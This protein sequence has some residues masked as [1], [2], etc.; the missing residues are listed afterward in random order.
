MD[1]PPLTVSGSEPTGESL[2]P[3]SSA[4]VN[5]RVGS[6][7][8]K[9]LNGLQGVASLFQ[10]LWVKRPYLQ[11]MSPE[12]GQPDVRNVQV[13]RPSHTPEHQGVSTSP[14]G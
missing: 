5:P 11:V 8:F 10:G 7:P 2:G 4:L 3:L 9:V 12:A 1:P 13:M 6:G 14:W